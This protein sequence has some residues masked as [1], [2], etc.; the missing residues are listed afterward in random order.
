M[1]KSLPGWLDLE[2]T[3]VK[4]LG[5]WYVDGP[6]E[7]VKIFVSVMNALQRVSILE[8]AQ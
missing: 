5:S 4:D 1:P 2:R 6:L 7:I 8:E 3:R